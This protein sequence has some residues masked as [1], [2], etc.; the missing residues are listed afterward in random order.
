MKLNVISSGIHAGNDL[1]QP[2]G[3]DCSTGSGGMIVAAGKRADGRDVR[4]SYAGYANAFK[5]RLKGH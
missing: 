3:K 1:E 5:F 2:S 4:L